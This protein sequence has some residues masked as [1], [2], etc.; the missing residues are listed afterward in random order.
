MHYLDDMDSKM[1]AMRTTLA[2]ESGHDEWTERNPALRRA[3]LRTDAYLGQQPKPNPNANPTATA[4]SVEAAAP[5]GTAQL[6]FE[7]RKA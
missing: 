6:D 2:S 4:K 1:A 7:P 5:R 3:I